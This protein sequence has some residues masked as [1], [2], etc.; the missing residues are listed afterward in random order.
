MGG[1]SRVRWDREGRPEGEG[2]G[3]ERIENGYK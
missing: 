2:K 1:G 3:K